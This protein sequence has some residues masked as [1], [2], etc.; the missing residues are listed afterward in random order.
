M[1]RFLY[2]LVFYFSIPFAIFRLLIKDTHDASWTRKLKNQFGIVEKITGRVIW[3]HCVSVGEFN[4]SK[5]LIEKLMSQYPNHQIV[6]ST[7]TITGFN[8][9]NNHYKNNVKHCFFPFDIPF[10]LESFIRKINPEICILLETE[11]WPNLI[12]TLKKK[13]IPSALIN[14]RLSDKSFQ[15][16]DKY[17]A[18]L[19]KVSLNSL[20]L[21][22]AQNSFS[23][24]RLIS[25]GANQDKMITT[26]SLKFD[27]D[28]IIDDKSIKTLKKI[29]GERKITVFAS[30]REGEEKQIIKSYINSADNINSLLIIIP[31]HPERFNEVFKLAKVG[32]LK[33][34]RRSTALECSK[35]TDILIGDTMGEMMSYYSVCDLAF[36]GGSLSDNGCQNMLEAASLSKPIIFGPSV[37]NFEEISKKLLMS[38]AAIQVANADELMSTI[39]ELLKSDQR[40]EQLGVNAKKTFDQNR[41]AVNKILEVITPLIKI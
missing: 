35:D 20:S 34:E 8:A 22:C 1:N 11:I 4:A 13:N 33:V 26:G 31:R 2:S 25:L 9:V 37:F 21:I 6:I 16:Y 15:R 23:S 17:S 12:N 41:G 14:A 18:K 27:S 7:T 10:I 30:T 36:I 38:D 40:R 19:V 28:N 24:D 5:P 3:T 29:I 32:G 39:S